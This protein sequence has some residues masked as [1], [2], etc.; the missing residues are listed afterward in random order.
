MTPVVAPPEATATVG[1]CPG[2]TCHDGRQRRGRARDGRVA[3]ATART[4]VK[5]RRRILLDGERL[6]ARIAALRNAWGP[7]QGVLHLA[8][9]GRPPIDATDGWLGE[10]DATTR[11]LFAV[12]KASVGDLTPA[13]RPAVILAVTAM[14]GLWGRDGC[15]PGAEL[16]AGCHGLLRTFEREYPEVRTV[17]VDVDD[18]RPATELAAQVMREVPRRR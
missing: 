10:L 8:P 2:C 12:L 5:S 1:S 6:S 13:R 4:W 18:S 11:S 9:L 14:G 7:V 16:A 15:R 3:A 17:V